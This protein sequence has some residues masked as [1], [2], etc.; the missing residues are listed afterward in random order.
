MSV[1]RSLQHQDW[2]PSLFLY[3]HLQPLQEPDSLCAVCSPEFKLSSLQP[4][5]ELF[6]LFISA[7]S[8]WNPQKF[9]NSRTCVNDLDRR[10]MRLKTQ[11]TL[12]R[13]GCWQWGNSKQ[14]WG[15]GS[16][17]RGILEMDQCSVRCKLHLHHKQRDNSTKCGVDG[18]ALPI[19]T[20][21]WRCGMQAKLKK[22]KI[23]G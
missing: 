1:G 19:M 16:D 17:D 13:H 8:C 18:Q 15:R 20:G 3:C 2:K 7:A 11:N 22:G 23:S 10:K 6:L 12:G 5:R 14:S 21:I 4:L 9:K